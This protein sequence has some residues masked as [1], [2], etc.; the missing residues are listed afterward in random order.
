MVR[1]EGNGNHYCDVETLHRL[2][3]SDSVTMH[4]QRQMNTE[5]QVFSI[6]ILKGEKLNVTAKD[7]KH[8][9]GGPHKAQIFFDR[10]EGALL[11]RLSWQD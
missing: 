2:L 3:S 4:V 7:D 10:E 8:G 11:Y 5:R 1:W 9:S 6:G